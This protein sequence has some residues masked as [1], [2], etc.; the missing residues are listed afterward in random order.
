MITNFRLESEHYYLAEH[1][2][3]IE[4]VMKKIATRECYISLDANDFSQL[5]VGNNLYHHEILCTADTR[6]EEVDAVCQRIKEL[7]IADNQPCILQIGTSK[8][9]ELT[10]DELQQIVSA[11][12]KNNEHLDIIFSLY[13][14]DNVD[15][16]L[17]VT[18]FFNE[19]KSG[20]IIRKLKL[21]TSSL[22]LNNDSLGARM[23]C[24]FVDGMNLYESKNAE[25]I[26]YNL[27]KNFN[28][29]PEVKELEAKDCVLN[30]LK[31]HKWAMLPHSS[32]IMCFNYFRPYIKVENGVIK[33][34]SE[35]FGLLKKSF[36]ID[37]EEK[38]DAVC[39]FEYDD[40]METSAVKGMKAN[41]LIDFHVKSGD[42][43]VFFETKY[44]EEHFGKCDS[45]KDDGVKL[46]TDLINFYN[47]SIKDCKALNVKEDIGFD[48]LAN[49]YQLFR[50]VIRITDKNK[51]VIFLYPG[52]SQV[53]EET[54]AFKEHYIDNAEL[55]D[56]VKFVNWENVKCSASF[57]EKYIHF[58]SDFKE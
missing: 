14:P 46:H 1:Q 35:M 23:Y 3:K 53:R 5:V 15:Y 25:E 13:Y 56:N 48:R 55:A 31:L 37:I 52:A 40:R 43:E 41:T 38:D 16:S 27:T 7:N 11:I 54:K 9:N 8:G 19:I 24:E 18:L 30:T 32:Q 28:L 47:Q 50:N 4:E 29:L 44:S 6:K 51:Y 20:E 21:K 58:R 17:S 57:K 12:R 33:P 49:D 26:N 36:G 42:K 34:T 45:W 2:D 39:C 22:Q 10:M